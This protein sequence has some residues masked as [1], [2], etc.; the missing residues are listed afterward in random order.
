MRS[1]TALEYLRA[2]Y[3]APYLNHFVSRDAWEGDYIRPLSLNQWNYV[4]GNPINY[5]DPSGLQT[6]VNGNKCD[7]ND[8]RNLTYWMIQAM[9]TNAQSPEIAEIRRLNNLGNRDI[10]K[11]ISETVIQ[12]VE[13]PAVERDLRVYEM[14][15]VVKSLTDYQYYAVKSE[16]LERFRA[17]V[18]DRA[19]WDFK[20]PL[21]KD[22]GTSIMLCDFHGCSWYGYEVVANIHFGY[23]GRAAGFT[24]FELHYGAGIAQEQDN[25]LPSGKGKWYALG[26][27]PE[28]YQAIDMGIYLFGLA[29]PERLGPWSFKTALSTYKYGL[30]KGEQPAD[31]YS[32]QRFEIDPELGSKFPVDHFN[33]GGQYE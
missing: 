17:L 2:R 24:W 27:E 3:Y 23:V 7:G 11:V 28:D 9:K 10:P 8:A 5:S 14:C 12:A 13:T 15:E 6:C 20:V 25:T 4:E 31:P 21:L 16:A 18:Q 1:Q 33:D 19:V 29:K 26:D 22:L 30:K 32:G